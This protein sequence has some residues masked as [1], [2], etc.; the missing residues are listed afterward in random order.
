MLIELWLTGAEAKHIHTVTTSFDYCRRL[1]NG[2][3]WNLFWNKP[4][5]LQVKKEPKVT[6]YRFYFFNSCEVKLKER[7]LFRVSFLSV[8]INCNTAKIFDLD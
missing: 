5:I 6:Q 2:N 3:T 1:E 7:S 4:L 8:G